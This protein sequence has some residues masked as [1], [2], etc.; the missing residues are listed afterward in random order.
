MPAF[1]K[2]PKFIIGVIVVLWVI[3]VIYANFQLTPVE[4][5]LFPWPLSVILQVRVSAV[6]IG[7]AIFGAVV[8]VVLQLAWRR[9][10]S[11]NASVSAALP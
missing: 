7:S 2:S 6:I 5:H 11:K 3:Y 10:P 1:T 8:A 4:I 9:R